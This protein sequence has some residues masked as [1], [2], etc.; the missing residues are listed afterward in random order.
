[1]IGAARCSS[2]ADSPADGHHVRQRE[3]HDV[4]VGGR[5]RHRDRGEAEQQPAGAVDAAGV[6]GASAIG[7]SRGGDVLAPCRSRRDVD[8]VVDVAGVA[9]ERAGELGGREPAVVVDA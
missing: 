7:G 6:A 2:S 9:V 3:H 1:M 8:G 4:G 5:E